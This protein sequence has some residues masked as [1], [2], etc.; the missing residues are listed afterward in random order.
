MTTGEAVMNLV[1]IH[2]L[3]PQFVEA[4]VVIDKNGKPLK[5]HNP[6]GASGGHLPDEQ[7]FFPKELSGARELWEFFDKNWRDIQGFAHSHPEGIPEP[8]MMD[9]TTF[10]GIELGLDLRFDWWI[11]TRKV[12][13]A[14][15]AGPGVYDYRVELLEQDPTWASELRLRS[16]RTNNVRKEL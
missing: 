15:W 12:A 11:V 1:N 2:D 3:K 7:R 16:R 8:S 14:R 9:V 10:A 5:W 13:V 4:G 6:D